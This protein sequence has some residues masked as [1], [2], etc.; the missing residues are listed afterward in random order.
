LQAKEEQQAASNPASWHNGQTDEAQL[1]RLI[2]DHHRWTGS[3]RAR[4]ILDN[5]TDMRARFVKI[6]PH[7]YK[8]VLGERKA[9]E[10]TQ[11]TIAKAKATP[12][13]QRTVPAK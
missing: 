1:R 3:L 8:R 11:A 9:V 12:I 7:E 6:L 4:E 13:K 5:W 2:E 10:D